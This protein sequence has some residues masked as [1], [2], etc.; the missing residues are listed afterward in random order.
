VSLLDYPGKVA[1]VLFAS[2]C[3]F[4]CPFC[5]NRELVLGQDITQL[6]QDEVLQ[7][8]QQRQGFIDG[9]VISGGEPTIHNGL[10][11]FIG[12][13]KETG[14]AVKL[15]TNGYKPDVLKELFKEKLLDY[16]A[17]DIKTSWGKYSKA[18][19]I[20]VDCERLK[21]SVELIK[22][23]GAQYEF[24]TTCVPGLVDESDIEEISR[25]T[26]K[27]GLFTLQQF[28]PKGT[29]D[30]SY[31]Q[32]TPYLPARLQYFLALARRNSSNCR[33]IGA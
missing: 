9:V 16:V 23:S 14:L 19:G 10:A 1:M 15:D 18:A 4:R 20:E 32:I 2:K 33:L 17:M 28:R 11:E 12:K 3:N 6:L 21:E 8:L 29:L 13:I 25:L 30:E 31:A 26:D 7:E 24:R 5:H 27:G 22:A